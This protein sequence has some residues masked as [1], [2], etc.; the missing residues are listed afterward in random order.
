M[1]AILHEIAVLKRTFRPDLVHLNTLGPSVLFHLQSARAA[2]AP[3][4][5]TMHSPVTADAAQTHSLYGRALQSAQ[6]VN[7][8][9]EAVHGDLCALLPAMRDRS[10]VTY[11]GMDEP[12]VDPAPRPHDVPVVLG[13]GRLVDDKGFDVAIRAFAEVRRA[14]PGAR[15]LLAGEGAARAGLEA[16]SADLGLN[17]AVTFT[18]AVAPDRIPHLINEASVVVVPSRWQEPFGLVALEA[19]LMARPVVAARVGGLP[20]VVEHGRTGFVVEPGDHV[21]LA[22]ALQY[23][24]ANFTEADSMGWDARARARE[25]FSWSYCVDAYEDLYERV[26]GIKQRGGSWDGHAG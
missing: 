24:L 21:A 7:C 10:S 18:G 25:R 13:Y 6:W 14:V 8:N 26:G 9:S 23:L 12:P 5:L 2:H 3:V 17:G 4:L 16:L 19:A 11:Y 22:Q 1:A 20:E 15:L